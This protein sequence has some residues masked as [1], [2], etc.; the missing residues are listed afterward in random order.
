MASHLTGGGPIANTGN[1]ECVKRRGLSPVGTYPYSTMTDTSQ[2]G[3]Q[4]KGYS[5]GQWSKDLS[6]CEAEGGILFQ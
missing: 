1:A 4:V 2:E 3:F 6:T 5:V